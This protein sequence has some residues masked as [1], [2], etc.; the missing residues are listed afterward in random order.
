MLT[1]KFNGKDN[2][3]DILFDK[4]DN[5]ITLIGNIIPSETGFKI[6]EGKDLIGDYSDYKTI[7]KKDNDFTQFSNDG[8]KYIPHIQTKPYEIKIVWEDNNNDLELRPSVVEV[9]TSMGKILLEESNG[10]SK[11]FTI[12]LEDTIII[13]SYDEIERYT[14]SENV[15][16]ITYKIESEQKPTIESRVD[17]LEQSTIELYEL[18]ER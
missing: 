3:Y 7:Y 8:S 16:V 6:Y 9:Q 14:S 17:S 2:S 11:T 12:P 10:Y 18:V 13:N 15:G 1:V 5:I 4:N